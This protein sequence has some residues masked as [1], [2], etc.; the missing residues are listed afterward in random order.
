VRRAVAA[1]LLGLVVVGSGPAGAASPTGSFSG[2]VTVL[3]ASSLTDAFTAMSKRFERKY[4]DAQVALSFNSSAMLATQ[5]EQGAP[6]DVIATADEE[7]MQRLVSG[8]QV[9]PDSFSGTEGETPYQIFARNRLAIAVQPGNPE[10]IRS[11]A[12]TLEPGLTVVLCAP[13]VPCGK[14]AA[15]AYGKAGLETPTGPT[16]LNAKDTLAKVELGEADA[17][18]VYV[19]DVKAAADDVDSVRIPKDE[20]VIARYPIAPIVGSGAGAKA[21]IQ[22]VDTGV[23]RRILRRYGF[24]P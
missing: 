4:P 13:E 14:L 10:H 16:G 6:A 17:A 18:I 12:D 8:G 24:L 2:E 19:T 22:F 1:L 7:T 5:I 21:F 11:L 23:G 15:T 20:N 3:A 9:P